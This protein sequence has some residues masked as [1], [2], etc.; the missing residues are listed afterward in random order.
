MFSRAISGAV[1]GIDANCVD[2]Q[3]DI[4]PG[5]PAFNI[6]GL[7]EKEVQ[8]S[9]ERIRSAIK[10]SGYEFPLKRITVNLAPADVKKEGVGLDLPLAVGILR[11]TGQIESESI[12]R[13]L[14]LGE[15][16]LDGHVRPMK[17]SLPVA[18]SCKRVGINSMI[19]P[20]QNAD[21]AA[22]VDELKVYGVSTLRE[23]VDFLQ[24]QIEIE[25]HCF[26]RESYFQETSHYEIDMSEI[27]GQE[28]AK[29]AME[30]AAAGGHN[31]LMVGPPGSGKSMLAAR[32]K[33]ILPPL[34]F[35]ESLEVTKI[36]SIMGLLKAGEPLVTKRPFRSPHHTISYAG[37]V[38]GGHGIPRPGEI[39]LAHCGILFLDELP[40]FER[41]VLE[42]LRQPLEER[43]ITLSRA[44]MALTFPANFTLI[45]AMNPCPCGHS[46]DPVKTC[47][48]SPV[49]IRRYRKKISGP[50][51]DRI[52]LFVEVPRLTKEELMGKSP[53][54]SS[55]EIRTRVVRARRLQT[56]RF[57]EANIFVNSQMGIQELRSFCHLEDEAKRLLEMAI[58]QYSLSARAYSRVLKVSRT[59]ADL[60][61]QQKIQPAHIAEAI[62]YRS[63]LEILEGGT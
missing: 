8:E 42:T 49:E 43:E 28:Q 24:G 30:I 13:S 4:S 62:Q 2:V 48:C 35:D 12:E 14:L 54:M 46:S 57:H 37:M 63:S 44:T 40:E 39:S 17:G 20:K 11:A 45:S 18:M 27:R 36:Y 6:V 29:R 25:P 21:E 1:I 47:T 51:L 61:S 55:D 52:D 38:G 5:M 53:G 26:D 31:L 59:I 32:L 9:R 41:P 23:T 10:N 22:V 7:P 19:V 3:C 50:F 58:D 16:S 33:T 34:T 60:E 15:L 56:A